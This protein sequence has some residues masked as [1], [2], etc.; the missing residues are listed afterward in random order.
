MEHLSFQS[1]IDLEEAERI[2]FTLVRE[3]PGM[4]WLNLEHPNSFAWGVG[5]LSWVLFLS[6]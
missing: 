5:S 6:P 1:V 2:Y 4:L 3:R